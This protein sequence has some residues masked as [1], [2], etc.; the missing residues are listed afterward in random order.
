[1]RLTA[2]FVIHELR[3]QGRSL[4][5]R[6]LA[7][8]YVLAG[9]APA[10]LIYARHQSARITAGSATYA[11]EVLTLLP[12]FTAVVALLIALDAVSREQDEGAWSTVSLAG[13]SSAGYLLRR[14][15]ALQAVLLPLTAVPVV[16]AG[17]FAAAALGPGAVTLG[18][19]LGPWLMQVIP[20]ALAVSALGLGLGTIAG[21]M[22]NACL[23]GA[24][25]LELVPMLLNAGLARFGIR[26]GGPLEWLQI[27]ELLNA[28]Q[29]VTAD[30]SPGSPWVGSFPLEM[31]E[32]PWDWRVAGEQYLALAALPVALAV[33]TLGI[34]VRHLRRTRPDVR[35]LR[36]RPDHPLRTF[37]NTVA[38]LRERY[39][40]DPRP[41][42]ADLAT[43]GLTLLVAAGALAVNVERVAR[44]QRYGMARYEMEATGGPDPTPADVVPGRW[45]VEGTLGPGREVA[46]T[47]TAEMRNQGTRPQGH[48]AFTLNPH[49]RVESAVLAATGAGS[50]TLSRRWDRLAVDLAPPIPPGGSRELRFRLRGEPAE[51]RLFNSSTAYWGFHKTF[52]NHLQAKFGRDLADL[53]KAYRVPALS[54]RRIELQATDLTP[55][56]RYQTWKM[57][58]DEEMPS[59]LRMPQ[60]VFFPAADL[61][62][63]LAAPPGVLVADSCGGLVSPGRPGRVQS[64]CRLAVSDLTVAGGHYLELPHPAGGAGAT[65]AVLPF[66]AALGALH[67]G[68]LAQG[69]SR[70]DEA[71]PGLGDLR[72]T[73]VLEW[74]DDEAFGLDAAWSSFRRWDDPGRSHIAVQGE[75]VRMTELDLVRTETLKPD[76]LVAELVAGRLARRRPAAPDDAQLVRMLLNNLVLQRLGTVPDGGA[77]VVGVR[78]GM[79]ATLSI[80]P[81]NH[82]YSLN[83]WN[84][85]FPALVTALRY[86]MGEEALRGAVEDVLS[87]TD[88]R[89]L[90]RGELYAA[91]EQRSAVPIGRMI[92]DFL[93][94][95]YLPQ[96]ILDGVEFHHAEGGWRVT[97]RLRNQSKGEAL[98]KVVLTTDR[99]RLE[100]TA[101]ADG[102][103]AGDFSFSTPHRPQ[104]VLLDPDRECHRLIPNAGARDRVFFA[105]AGGAS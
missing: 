5:F 43:L 98:C 63:D 7:A 77:A 2:A 38:R 85:R 101:R 48:L 17:G 16:A 96:P 19:L 30:Y 54:P 105:G 91:I 79:E 88:A 21:G 73:V 99:G 35:P 24:A 37:L 32:S 60:E 97:G 28:I 10:A 100:T 69:T 50:L 89:P 42:R 75:L 31:T 71:W 76:A 9:S 102:D 67:L 52:G 94:Q 56:P 49:V 72:R 59:L 22:L 58:A 8:L 64:H 34:A 45:R 51:D 82:S 80:P 103:Q 61:S 70:L 36:V 78:T 27:R 92:R 12:A 65:V 104:A 87:R 57:Y 33:A 81:P 26:L 66:H 4:R 15:L 20:I 83:Y 95:G 44:Y 18:P 6:V 47:V 11:A 68:F 46:V 39:T 55:V 40:P 86:R 84:N 41:S 13:T 74:P 3:T 90:T 1:M 23:L 62:L 29:R 14:W 25:V 53:S 93:V